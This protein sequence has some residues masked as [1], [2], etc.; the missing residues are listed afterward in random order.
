MINVFVA[1]Q[2]LYIFFCSMGFFTFPYLFFLFF[3]WF[4]NEVD[5]NKQSSYTTYI[6]GFDAEVKWAANNVDVWMPKAV[7]T[8]SRE[9]HRI[10]K[11]NIWEQNQTAYRMLGVASTASISA[12]DIDG[13]CV[14]QKA[15][16]YK[17]RWRKL[18]QGAKIH[19][20]LLVLFAVSAAAGQILPI[21][22]WHIFFAQYLHKRVS[23]FIFQFNFLFVIV[24]HLYLP[25]CYLSNL[26]ARMLSC[27]LLF[28]DVRARACLKWCLLVTDW[29]AACQSQCVLLLL[30]KT[31]LIVRAHLNT[32]M[33]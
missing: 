24:T 18:A 30:L 13:V 6:F 10:N 3:F 19:C 32:T 4:M 8:Q 7:Q 29:L 17:M 23:L 33:L 31:F 1:S 20:G 16:K 9:W 5:E 26:F 12:T 28:M 27:P 22:L 21:H 11:I 14:K 25:I 15:K 2:I